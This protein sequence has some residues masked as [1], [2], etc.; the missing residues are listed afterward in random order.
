MDIKKILTVLTR[1]SIGC[2]LQKKIYK[3]FMKEPIIQQCLDILKRDDIRSELK[4]F[5]SPLFQMTFDFIQPYI[6]VML[7]LIFL[8]FVMILA[9]LTLLILVLRNKSIITKLF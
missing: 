5:C 6:Y 8:I 2:L 3:L 9:I 1:K 7:F 4:S